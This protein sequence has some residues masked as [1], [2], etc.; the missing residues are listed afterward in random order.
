MH[1]HTPK[2]HQKVQGMHPSHLL[3]SQEHTKGPA[4]SKWE[5]SAYEP[6]PGTQKKNQKKH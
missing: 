6:L 5:Q 4:K 1:T 2:V 3:Y